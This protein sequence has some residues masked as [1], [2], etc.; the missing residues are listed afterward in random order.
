MKYI[1]G[2]T[3]LNTGC[4]AL[5]EVIAYL[6]GGVMIS[7]LGVKKSFISAFLFSVAGSLLIIFIPAGSVSGTAYA[8]FVLTAKFGVSATF[9]MVYIVTGEFFPAALLGS[10]FGFCNLFARGFTFLSP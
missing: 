9:N 4:S 5:S 3:F 10:A 7:K 2:N 6:V 8:G 1:N